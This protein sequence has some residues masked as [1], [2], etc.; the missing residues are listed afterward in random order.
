MKRYK[1]GEVF[2][3]EGMILKAIEDD[4]T[5]KERGCRY[6]ALNNFMCSHIDCGTNSSPNIRFIEVSSDLM[7]KKKSF[8]KRLIFWRKDV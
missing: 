4:L 5:Q 8:W 6:C 1:V 3:Y 7:P 2:E